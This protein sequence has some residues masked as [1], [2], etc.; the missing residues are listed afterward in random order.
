MN[1]KE[2]AYSVSCCSACFC[3]CLDCTYVSSYHNG[4]ES[5]AYVYLTDESYVSCF[6]HSI[7]CFDGSYETPGFYHS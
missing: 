1:G 5:A 6:Y 2:F 4:Y 3:S 7:C